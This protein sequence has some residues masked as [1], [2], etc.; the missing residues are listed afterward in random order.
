[1]TATAVTSAG[2]VDACRDTSPGSD[3]GNFHRT[4]PA[5]GKI[6]SHLPQA[7]RNGEYDQLVDLMS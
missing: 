6:M 2:G 3:P 1:M 5:E 7:I 4:V